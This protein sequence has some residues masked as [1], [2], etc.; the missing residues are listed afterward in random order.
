MLPINQFNPPLWPKPPTIG[1]ALG[2]GGLRGAAHIGVLEVLQAH[3]LQIDMIAGTSA[4]SIVAML[5]ALGW[6]PQ[7]MIDFV[8]ELNVTDYADY[9]NNILAYILMGLHTILDRMAWPHR[10]LP[11]APMGIIKGNRLKRLL[12]KISDSKDFS[13]VELPLLITATE[14]CSG[15]L[16]CFCPPEFVPILNSQRPEIVFTGECSLATAVRASTSIPGI[17]QPIRWQNRLLVDGGVKNNVPSDLL[18]WAGADLVIAVDLG[19][20]SQANNE[21]DTILEILLQSLD[22]MGQTSTE[23]RLERTAD[24]VIQP[25]TDHASL[26][27]VR[28]IPAIIEAG[29][30]AATSVW[31]QIDLLIRNF[32]KRRLAT[33][34][35]SL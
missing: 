4:G 11:S 12:T 9:V 17:F 32:Y 16:V 1:L 8:L 19:F 10:W 35:Y 30:Q 3:G 13:Q 27:E 34:P 26:S 18:R 22:I 21:I 33:P 29:R 6:L 25:K 20:A 7:D 23:I 31:P 5:H 2:G 15:R 14:I 24:I 28:K